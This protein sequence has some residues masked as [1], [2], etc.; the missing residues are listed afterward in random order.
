MALLR[1]YRGD[2]LLLTPPLPLA[3]KEIELISGDLLLVTES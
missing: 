1:V 2:Q 3:W